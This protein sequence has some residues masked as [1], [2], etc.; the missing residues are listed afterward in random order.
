MTSSRNYDKRRYDDDYGGYE[1][2]YY[3]D[4]NESSEYRSPRRIRRSYRRRHDE[5]REEDYDSNYGERHYKERREGYSRRNQGKY[6]GY[7]DNRISRRD[8]RRKNHVRSNSTGDL[9]NLGLLRDDYKKEK[10]WWEAMSLNGK[11]MIYLPGAVFGLRV[12]NGEIDDQRKKYFFATVVENTPNGLVAKINSGPFGNRIL[13]SS[14][15][16]SSAAIIPP[17]FYTSIKEKVDEDM[18]FDTPGLLNSLAC[19]KPTVVSL[20]QPPMKKPDWRVIGFWVLL[21]L[22]LLAVV[23]TA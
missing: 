7:D 23:V 18:L 12:G 10:N 5:Y 6:R 19:L 4:E 3:D 8:Q 13:I 14:R 17:N 22:F 2:P 16:F 11:Q 21:A 9:E 1:E 20:D 15:S